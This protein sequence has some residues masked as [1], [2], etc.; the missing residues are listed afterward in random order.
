MNLLAQM[1]GVGLIILALVD[2]Y[3]T[4]LYPRIGTSV[5]SF[6]LGKAVWRLFRLVA[7]AIPSKSDQLLSHSGPTLVVVTVVVWVSLLICGFAFII[8]PEL[9]SAIQASQGQTPIDWVTALYYSGFSF[10]TLG[11]GDIVPKT[12][13]YRLLTL[14]EAALGFSTFTLTITY[15]LSVYSALVRRNTFALSLHHR[16]AGTADAAEILVQLGAN[17]NFNGAQQDVSKMARD[18]MNLL[19]V[20]HSY[21]VLLY[22]RFPQTYYALP[23]MA[24]IAMDT[25]TLIRSALNTEKY[26][27]LVRST[28]VAEL[29][30]GGLQLLVELSNSL[31]SKNRT[32]LND[33]LEQVWRERY[34]HAV[35][36]LR[37]EG[38]ETAADLEAGANLYISLRR[39]WE[40]CLAVLIDYMAYKWSEVAPAE[41]ERSNTKLRTSRIR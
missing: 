33:Q 2:I 16:T 26:R 22:F 25:V 8:Y 13:T 39:K 14:L 11:T 28:A 36:R 20:Q 6:Q 3:L 17:G 10:T 27:S 21:P 4:V 29:W 15:L 35:E 40:P 38:I 18:L 9:G 30:G 24:L 1:V 31:V 7:G 12:G 41:M 32:N 19:E 37:A 34:H 5:L 23:R